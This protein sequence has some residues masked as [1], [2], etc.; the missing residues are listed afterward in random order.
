MNQ[1]AYTCPP[2][3]HQSKC[4]VY[5]LFENCQNIS[6]NDVAKIHFQLFTVVNKLLI[7]C[8]FSKWSGIHLMNATDTTGNS[9][10]DSN[11]MI[12]SKAMQFVFVPT[13]F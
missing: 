4:F 8:I 10:S 12:I 7:F 9:E 13:I 2:N 11:M 5:L 3:F 6:K 1:T